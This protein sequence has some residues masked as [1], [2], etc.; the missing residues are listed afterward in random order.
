MRT[1]EKFSGILFILFVGYLLAYQCILRD[2]SAEPYWFPSI[3]TVDTI[4][5]ADPNFVHELIVPIEVTVTI[6]YPVEEQ[7]DDSPNILADGTKINIEKAGS[8]RYCALSRDLLSRWG[9]SFDYGQKIVLK[10]V[11]NF[12]GEWVVRDTMH[13][14]WKNRVDLLTDIGTTPIKFNKAKLYGVM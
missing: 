6:Y 3:A 2:K 9:G 14:R 1:L 12:E 10:G 11:K 5:L 7:C 13:P 8:Y 4:K